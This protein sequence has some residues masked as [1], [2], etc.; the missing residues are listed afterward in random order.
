MVKRLH[1]ALICS[2]VSISGYVLSEEGKE[3]F[4][5]EFDTN[6]GL[7]SFKNNLSTDSSSATEGFRRFLTQ[8]N[9]NFK[10]TPQLSYR[11]DESHTVYS[12]TYK[13][14]L[15]DPKLAFELGYIY[16][17]EAGTALDLSYFNGRQ[18]KETWESPYQLN[19][20]AQKTDLIESGFRIQAKSIMGSNFDF[21]GLYFTRD[22]DKESV[23]YKTLERTGSGYS[24]LVEYSHFINDHSAFVPS[25]NYSSFTAEGQATS[26]NE[27]GGGLDFMQEFGKHALLFGVDYMLRDFDSG[28]LQFGNKVQS[29]NLYE[30][31]LLYQYQGF[32]DIE[33]MK[34]LG[35]MSY[36]AN[37]SN[38]EF[39]DTEEY[40]IM[41]GATYSF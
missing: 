11:F 21:D 30:A 22:V 12:S 17:T 1:L 33:E 18:P 38:I 40:Q 36:E 7:I 23:S 4:S 20:E 9:L 35:L 2:L 34:L 27:Y 41:F 19:T 25:L 15:I 39:Y 26:Y 24:G 3:T 28:N 6:F 32:L 31:S 16:H 8:D 10:A 14:D 13:Q 37:S 29:D 5:A